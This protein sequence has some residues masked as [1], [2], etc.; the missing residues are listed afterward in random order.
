M[1]EAGVAPLNQDSKIE[2]ADKNFG[3]NAPRRACILAAQKTVGRRPHVQAERSKGI[4][5]AQCE[6]VGMVVLA[7]AAALLPTPAAG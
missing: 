3:R 5:R 2:S 7:L 4:R 1:H 6:S